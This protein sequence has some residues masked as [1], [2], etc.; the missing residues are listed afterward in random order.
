MTDQAAE[1][2]V[3]NDSSELEAQKTKGANGVKKKSKRKVPVGKKNK[4]AKKITRG[5]KKAKPVYNTD[6]HPDTGVMQLQELLYY[7]LITAE[8]QVKLMERDVHIAKSQ[9]RDFQ[10]SAN[11]Q[12]MVFQEKIK[13]KAS[14]LENAKVFHIQTVNAIEK[15]TGLSL[16][17]WAIDDERVLRPIEKQESSK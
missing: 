11:Q 10:A 13:E 16:K 17:D 15:E 6:I 9:A 1:A 3:E 7:K 2:S 12:L 5:K 14:A 4:V 8:Q